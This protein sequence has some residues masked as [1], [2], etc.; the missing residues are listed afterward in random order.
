MPFIIPLL[1]GLFAAASALIGELIVFSLINISRNPF[2]QTLTQ[3]DDAIFAAA[4]FGFLPIVALL[5]ESFKYLALRRT[6]PSQAS[7]RSFFLFL[8]IFGIGFSGLET[9]LILTRNSG[10]DVTILPHVAAIGL[11]HLTTIFILGSSMRNT[12]SPTR[13]VPALF[14]TTPLHFAYNVAASDQNVPFEIGIVLLLV[15]I[16]IF[17]FRGSMQELARRKRM[18]YNEGDH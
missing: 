4:E 16:A 18:T 13:S 6:L 3:G 10:L 9:T 14:L 1:S 11:L 5:E 12:T 8:L 17:S 15:I 7:S 2:A